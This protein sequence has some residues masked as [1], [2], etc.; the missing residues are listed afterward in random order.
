MALGVD[1]LLLGTYLRSEGFS[2]VLKAESAQEAFH[3]LGLPT[4]VNTPCVELVIMDV[5]MPEINGI[6][7]LKHIKAAPGAE[8]IPILMTSAH[9]E[10]E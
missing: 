5:L 7:A 6:Q 4:L 10:S 2:E 3:Y 1:R 8:D 9:D